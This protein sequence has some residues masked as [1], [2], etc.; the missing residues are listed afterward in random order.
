MLEARERLIADM[1]HPPTAGELATSVGLSEKRLNAGFRIEFGATVF[2]VLRNERLEHARVAIETGYVTLKHVAFRVGYNY[3]NNFIHAFTT[4][5]GSPP[6][7]Y[8]E[9]HKRETHAG[10]G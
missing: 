9:R 5:Y 7:R 2:E 1:R 4:R 10:R 6:R 8:A 3:V